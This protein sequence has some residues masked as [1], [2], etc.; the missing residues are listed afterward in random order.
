MKFE[1]EIKNMGLIKIECTLEEAIGLRKEQEVILES[2]P[3]YLEQLGAA[4]KKFQEI[5]NDINAEALVNNLLH[6]ATNK[7]NVMKFE[8]NLEDI[9]DTNN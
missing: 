8:E 4:Y 1:M 6:M 3:K 5:D 7:S 2:M 9:F